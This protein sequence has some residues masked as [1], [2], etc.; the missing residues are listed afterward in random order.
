MLI[1]SDISKELWHDVL[2]CSRFAR[3]MWGAAVCGVPVSVDTWVSY[4]FGAIIPNA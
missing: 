3:P 1:N 4:E 2:S